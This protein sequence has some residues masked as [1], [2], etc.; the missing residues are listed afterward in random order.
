MNIVLIN[1]PRENEIIGNNPR[2]IESERGCNPPLGILYVAAYLEK[3]TT[4]KVTVV[5]AQ[6]EELSYSQLFE[7][8]T[9]LQP[10]VV[11]ITTMTLTLID[12]IKT[13]NLVKSISNKTTVVLGGPHVHLF[14]EETM[15]LPGVDFLVLG[16]GEKTFK[17]LLDSIHDK[18]KL[19]NIP[20]IVFSYDGEIVNTG[21]SAVIENLDELPFPDRR[22]VPY[23]K[24]NSLLAVGKVATSIFTSRGCPFKCTFCDRPHL[25]K[26]FRA[27]S[28]ENVV[29]EIEICSNMGITDFL[30]Y[31]D[32]FTVER[33]R[34]LDICEEINRRKL[35]VMFDIRSRVDTI[36]EQMIANLKSAGCQGIH[37]GIEAGTEKIL[38]VLNKKISLKLAKNI[39]DITKKNKIASLAYFMIGNPEETIKDIRETFNVMKN[40]NPDYVHLTILTPFPGTQV[41]FDAMKSGIIARDVWRDFARNPDAKFIPP[42]WG[43]YFSREELNFLL[44]VGYRKFY[45][46]PNYIFRRLLKLR[47]WLEFKRKAKAGLGV[48]KMKAIKKYSKTGN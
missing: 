2:I 36:D 18:D 26:N 13:V 29:D 17:K 10:D 6:V 15:N 3:Y 37:Y 23:Q 48:L 40:L 9:K 35:N 21:A 47:S 28:P 25:G 20:G 5:D 8:I 22:L 43:Q 19:L 44:T 24:Y 30:I 7:K 16:E 39:F 4:H 31:D 42:H 46:R 1:P 33:Q 32:T 14:P 41:Y 34:V 12:V 27:R 11:G 38:K 45:L